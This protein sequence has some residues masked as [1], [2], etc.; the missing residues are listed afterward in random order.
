MMAG[1]SEVIYK[2]QGNVEKFRIKVSLERSSS[3]Q[4][5]LFIK[6]SEINFAAEELSSLAES[7]TAD[8]GTKSC[9]N[10]ADFDEAVLETYTFRWKERVFSQREVEVYSNLN[11]CKSATELEYHDQVLKL[12]VSDGRSTRRLFSI[13][14]CDTK[15][16]ENEAGWITK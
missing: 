9:I 16:A 6:S 3:K 15:P 7:V 2:F 8:E 12:N 10:G 1:H 4:K 13:V 11:N 14:E 5:G